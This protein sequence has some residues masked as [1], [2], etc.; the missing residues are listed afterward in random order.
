MTKPL[1]RITYVEDDQ[2]I[3]AI[4]ELAL[5]TLAGYTL[6]LCENGKEAVEAIPAFQPDLVLLDVMMPVM[7]GMETLKRLKNTPELA[8]IPVIFM[9]AKAQR[10]EVQA[11]KD[12]GAI[13][14]ITK[15]FDPMELPANVQKIWNRQMHQNEQ[16]SEG[17]S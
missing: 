7:D 2:D 17:T 11:Y 8:D 6:D 12:K 14:V 16:A 5:G 9:T 10:H 4:A 1:Q 15:P 13:D 3:R